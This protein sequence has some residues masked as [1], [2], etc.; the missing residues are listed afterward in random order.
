M[1]LSLT[2]YY[3]HTSTA[4]VPNSRRGWTRAPGHV[5]AHA[6]QNKTSPPPGSPQGVGYPL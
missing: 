3:L 2:F 1:R 4:F 5:N 6:P